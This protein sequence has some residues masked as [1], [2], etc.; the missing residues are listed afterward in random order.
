MMHCYEL[1]DILNNKLVEWKELGNCF[2]K[3][4]SGKLIEFD[5]VEVDENGN[6]IVST[7]TDWHNDDIVENQDSTQHG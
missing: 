2:Y 6:L 5:Y 1:Q 4:K 7:Y 3:D